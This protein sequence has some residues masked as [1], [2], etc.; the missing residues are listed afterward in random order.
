[1]FAKETR[2]KESKLKMLAVQSYFIFVLPSE[3][4]FAV[5]PAVLRQLLWLCETCWQ[6]CLYCFQILL[7]MESSILCRLNGLEW[8]V[9]FRNWC[10]ELFWFFS[11]YNMQVNTAPYVG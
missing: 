6:S 10:G 7:F 5:R 2:S 1:M 3:I 4:C 8:T 9:S 11:F